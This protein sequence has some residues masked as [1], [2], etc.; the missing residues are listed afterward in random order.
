MCI[1]GTN[2]NI[3]IRIQLR[4]FIISNQPINEIIESK[5]FKNLTFFNE[6]EIA[7]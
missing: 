3:K 7:K 4:E 1:L 5:E 6:E 2:S